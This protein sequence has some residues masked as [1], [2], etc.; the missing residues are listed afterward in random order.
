MLDEPARGM[1]FAGRGAGGKETLAFV[2]S[3]EGDRDAEV[4]PLPPRVGDTDF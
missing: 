4:T 3:D 1:A 2:A